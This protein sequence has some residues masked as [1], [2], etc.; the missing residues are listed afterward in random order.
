VVDVFRCS[1]EDCETL[2]FDSIL[3]DVLRLRFRSVHF[4]EFYVYVLFTRDI[5]IADFEFSPVSV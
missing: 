2:S 3:I 5:R 1:V 4:H